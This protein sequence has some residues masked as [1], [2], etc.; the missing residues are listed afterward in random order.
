MEGTPHTFLTRNIAESDNTAHSRA[1]AMA[2]GFS[3]SIVGGAIV[4]G[5]MIRPLVERFGLSWLGRSWAEVRFKSPAYDGDRLETRI[6]TDGEEGRPAEVTSPSSGA[7]YRLRTF[8][9]EGVELVEMRAGQLA[10]LQPPDPRWALDPV[11]WHGNRLEGTW[12]RM[13]VDQPFRCFRWS[14]TLEEQLDYCEATAEDLAVYREGPLPPA[15]PGLLLAQGSHVVS[16]QFVMPF[17][18]HASSRLLYRK[19]IRVGDAVELRCLPI[20]KWKRG[21]NEWVRFY[22]VYLVDGEPAVEV[23]K[24]SVIKVAKRSDS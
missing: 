15:H 19:V 7:S 10:A 17:W 9:A 21:A 16:N 1:G 8:N 24:T 12:E 3:G 23:W 11:E 6:D 4:Y 5:Q 13:V 18:I 2:K 14:V 22:Q 20:D